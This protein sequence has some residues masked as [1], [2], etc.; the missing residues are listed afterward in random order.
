MP[1][2][3][4]R[5]SF[6]IVMECDISPLYLIKMMSVKDNIAFQDK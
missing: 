1:V 4:K 6:D 5:M 2:L 3:K